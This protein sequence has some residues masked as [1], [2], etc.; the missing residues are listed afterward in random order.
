MLLLPNLT[1]LALTGFGSAMI[2]SSPD[3]IHYDPQ[4]I[5]RRVFLQILCPCPWITKHLDCIHRCRTSSD[6]N[7]RLPE[8]QAIK[9]ETIKLPGEKSR[10]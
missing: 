5:V 7:D 6:S 10:V 1:L 3:L 8:Y 4:A 2:K 9:L